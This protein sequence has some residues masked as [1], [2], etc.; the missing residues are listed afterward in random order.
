MSRAAPIPYYDNYPIYSPTLLTTDNLITTGHTPPPT[1]HGNMG[2]A[3][4]P[5]P[6]SLG[7]SGQ[8]GFGLNKRFW[9]REG[10]YDMLAYYG[11]YHGARP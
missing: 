2:T 4:E 10:L 3:P 9:M 7:P 5:Y 1:S 6:L 11:A 8:P